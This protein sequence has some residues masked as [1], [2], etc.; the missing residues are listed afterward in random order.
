MIQLIRLVKYEKNLQKGDIMKKGIIST[1]IFIVFLFILLTVYENI[2]KE[3]DYDINLQDNNLSIEEEELPNL[4]GQEED[5][6]QHKLDKQFFIKNRRNLLRNIHDN[7]IVILFSGRASEKVNFSPSRNFYYMT[8]IDNEDNILLILK[9]NGKIQ[10]TLFM[11]KPN[12]ELEEWI[13]PMMTDKE[14]EELS[15]IENIQSIDLF[16]DYLN[17]ILSSYDIESIYLDLRF[18][19]INNL[20]EDI[21]DFLSLNTVE[22]VFGINIKDKYNEVKVKDLSSLVSQQRVIK[23]FGEI[24]NIKKAVD[25]TNEGIKILMKKIKPGL[26]EYQLES[27]FDF[28]IKYLGAGEHAFPTIAASGENAVVI[29]YQ[30][31]NKEIK[32]GELIL[33]DL[34]ASY[35]YYSS[36]ISRTFPVNGKFSDRQKQIYNIVLKA[37]TETI[38][39]VK[40]GITLVELDNIA[41]NIL[42]DECIKIGLINKKSQIDNYYKHFIGHYL[43]LDT[44]DPGQYD[45][46]LKAGM[47]IT[48]EPGL[49]IKEEGIGIRIEDNILVTDDGYINLS[50]NIIK[51]VEEIEDF[52]EDKKR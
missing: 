8:G 33:F 44:H 12:Y 19:D 49:Y 14:A 28:A 47:V 40:P 52:M 36:D 4:I 18:N 2:K 38:K 10:E 37:Q 39:A 9:V 35:R 25:I 16:N 1:L 42:A 50:K 15:G 21:N 30:N 48:I 51:T 7:S 41:K 22:Q 13:G 45:R 24:E 20:S 43:G 46:P 31:N 6:Y 26:K 17:K 34:G 11:Q 27:Y 23:S 3:K 32:D 29:H 5:N